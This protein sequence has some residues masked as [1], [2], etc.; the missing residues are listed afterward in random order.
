MQSSFDIFEVL[1][2]GDLMWR[3]AVAGREKAIISLHQIA[4]GQRN[5]FRLMDLD[6]LSLV[7][8]TQKAIAHLFLPLHS[9]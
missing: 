1:P 4:M 9:S 7:A 8:T 2:S 3:T 6:S 5:E